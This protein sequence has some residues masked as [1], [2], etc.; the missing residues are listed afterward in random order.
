M[1]W[2]AVIAITIAVGVLVGG[3]PACA[4]PRARD[5]ARLGAPRARRKNRA[6]K[7]RRGVAALESLP[8]AADSQTSRG[9]M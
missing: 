8:T 9:R 5:A 2:K 6:K 1:T 3:I 7:R 4:E